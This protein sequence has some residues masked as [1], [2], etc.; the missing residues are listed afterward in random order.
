MAV[1]QRAAAPG[2][3][4]F[5]IEPEARSANPF[6]AFVNR[7]HFAAWLLLIAAPVCG[8]FIARLRIHPTCRGGT[9]AQSIGQFMRSGA[10]VHGAC[11]DSCRSACCC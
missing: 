7:N 2:S 6:G 9:G 8:Y 10:R 4:L 11:R 5:L 1:I 3:V